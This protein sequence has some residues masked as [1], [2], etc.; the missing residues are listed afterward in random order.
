[1]TFFYFFRHFRR[2]GYPL[3]RAISRAWAK[4]WERPSIP[5]KPLQ[6]APRGHSKK[7]S[8]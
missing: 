7:R 2:S 3:R 5:F 4:A 1:M 8:V 6:G